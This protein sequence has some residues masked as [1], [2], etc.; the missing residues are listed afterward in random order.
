MSHQHPSHIKNVSAPGQRWQF[1]NE[2]TRQL[3]K[4]PR[5]CL[6]E[7][8]GDLDTSGSDRL[9]S[10]MLNLKCCLLI[11]D[12]GAIN[13]S[14]LATLCKLARRRR[15]LTSGD[16]ALKIV[17]YFPGFRKLT[18]KT[19][20]HST[21]IASTCHCPSS[22]PT[23]SDTIKSLSLLCAECRRIK[24]SFLPQTY[25][26][27]SIS[28]PQMLV[29]LKD[30][31]QGKQVKWWIVKGDSSA[32]GKDIYITP[33]LDDA[34]HYTQR[35][36]PSHTT[37]PA[38]LALEKADGDT[39]LET[40]PPTV[41]T[42]L[43]SPCESTST[44]CPSP[45]LPKPLK[46]VIQEYL[47]RPMTIRDRK[48][49]IRMWVLLL[50]PDDSSDIQVYLHTEGVCRLATLPYHSPTSAI[51]TPTAP[52]HDNLPVPSS[53][54]TVLSSSDEAKA[55]A[56]KPSEAAFAH[57]TNHCIQ[58]L[59][60][61]FGSIQ[62]DN[63]MYFADFHRY[64]LSLGYPPSCLP[65]LVEQ[66]GEIVKATI[67][68][69][70]TKL[71][72]GLPPSGLRVFQ[73]LGYDFLVTH[74][75]DFNVERKQESTDEQHLDKS[76]G[77]SGNNNKSNNIDDLCVKLL[78]VNATP[79]CAD[80][81]LK[82]I[83]IDTIHLAIDPSYSSSLVSPPSSTAASPL[84]PEASVTNTSEVDFTENDS[85]LQLINT[86]PPDTTP[87]QTDGS[88]PLDLPTMCSTQLIVPTLFM[89]LL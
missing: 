18:N 30:S 4:S 77:N 25:V 15:T 29:T 81:L 9:P 85:W 75:Q 49:D 83:C 21:I 58:L 66:M 2:L 39:P 68:A 46:W 22:L 33:S 55:Y 54:D 48:F 53:L 13:W 89:K 88:T 10:T 47:D 20:M 70:K 40:I 23:T 60:P 43:S 32:G 64:L 63:L 26:I 57:I 61:E 11:A 24:C 45:S 78:E 16:D 41:P 5:W 72:E 67:H 71:L 8:E 6:D 19:D 59:H 82:R 51:T 44:D 12:R 28:N 65:S 73:L 80:R 50:K 17:N 79:A 3:L 84:I 7:P 56:T 42:G 37:N 34:I 14:A 69:S 76:C 62:A 52:Q 35:T 27:D 36:Q 38:S 1:F 86:S 31:N 87:T 74:S